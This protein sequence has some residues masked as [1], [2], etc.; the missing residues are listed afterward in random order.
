MF[1]EKDFRILKELFFPKKKKKRKKRRKK[2]KETLD[3]MFND[4]G[5]KIMRKIKTGKL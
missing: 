2:K 4:F 3:G 5:K 1:D